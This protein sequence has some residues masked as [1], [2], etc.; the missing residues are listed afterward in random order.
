MTNDQFWGEAA[1]YATYVNNV[2][3]HKSLEG[4]T[5]FEKLFGRAPEISMVPAREYKARIYVAK[6]AG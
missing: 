5:L 1:R 6:E 2:T 3:S 4:N